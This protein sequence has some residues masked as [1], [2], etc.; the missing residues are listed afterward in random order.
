MGVCLTKYKVAL[1]LANTQEHR[2]TLKEWLSENARS[3]PVHYKRI[4]KSLQRDPA[5]VSASLSIERKQ[6][7][8]EKRPAY[9][10]KAGPGLYQYNE[11]CDGLVDEE[12]IKEICIRVDDFNKATRREMGNEIAHLDM[13][14]FEGLVTILLQEIRMRTSEIEVIKRT[15]NSLLLVTS[16][17]NDSS[18]SRIV[19]YARKCSLDE[20]VNADI[21]SEV[22]GSLHING[23]NQGILI[24]NGVATD[25]AKRES[26]GLR[27]DESKAFV[28]PVHLI[29]IEMILNIL[30]ESRIGFQ[31]R[32]IELL[33][34]DHDFFHNLKSG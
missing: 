12:S 6:A 27:T 3:E 10:V 8:E 28:S 9:F 24:T 26:L 21:V 4:A 5:S 25:D 32:A 22:R 16:W 7:R 20:P 30:F 33:L 15:S 18:E 23:A 34:L 14:D 29:D 2:H 19:I 11:L 13:S 17:R 31:S 1:D